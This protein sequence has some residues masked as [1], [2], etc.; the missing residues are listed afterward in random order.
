MI[1]FREQKIWTDCLKKSIC[2]L[3]LRAVV[4]CEPFL[5]AYLTFQNTIF[6][7]KYL[8]DWKFLTQ[9]HIF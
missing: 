6:D 3:F 4:N 9:T 1:R 5:Q 7:G 8:I 2:F